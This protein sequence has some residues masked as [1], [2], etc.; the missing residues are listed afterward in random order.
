MITVVFYGRSLERCFEA[1]QKNTIDSI[2]S[3]H[4]QYGFN[5]KKVEFDLAPSGVLG[6]EQSFV[7]LIKNKG[8]TE[9][10]E[11]SLIMITKKMS[12]KPR[13]I[14]NLD[15]LKIS[16]GKPADFFIYD[17]KGKTRIKRN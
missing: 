10:L 6:L 4:Q 1:V 3:G 12:E 17:P 14:L 16:E 7:Q 13:E 15:K 5:E 11:K 2:S 9:N 8:D